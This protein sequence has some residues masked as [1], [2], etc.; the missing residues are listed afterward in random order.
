MCTSNSTCTNINFT[1]RSTHIFSCSV[2]IRSF[3]KCQLLKSIFLL[4]AKSQRNLSEDKTITDW[5]LWPW[6]MTAMRTCSSSWRYNTRK[7]S[8]TFCRRVNLTKQTWS[9]FN[10]KE[11]ILGI[12]T[13]FYFKRLNVCMTDTHNS[14]QNS[15]CCHASK[16][17]VILIIIL[18]IFTVS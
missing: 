8:S 18:V 11:N 12:V 17:H 3:L 6:R 16:H 10:S 5:N 7:T 9:H 14:Y 4:S 2:G 15:Q 1:L 13:L